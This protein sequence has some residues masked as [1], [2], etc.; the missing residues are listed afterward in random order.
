MAQA[1]AGH[2]AKLL[3][4]ACHWADGT[5]WCSGPTNQLRKSHS[6]DSGVSKLRTGIPCALCPH[7]TA[8]LEIPVRYP[9][10]SQA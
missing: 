2:D 9:T 1:L 3:H 10:E 7:D 8:Q 4:G 5:A 6:L